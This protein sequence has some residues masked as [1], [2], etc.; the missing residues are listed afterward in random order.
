[1]NNSVFRI[2]LD[3]HRQTTQAHL[4]IKKGDTARKIVAALSD[5]GRPYRI[6]EGCCAVFKG[7]KSDG[8]VLYN[9][10]TVENNCIVYEFTE[11][12]AA[13]AGYMP[14]EFQIYGADG[15]I[16]TSP[17]FAII[18]SGLVYDDSEVESSSEFTALAQ[19]MTDLADLKANGL[20]GDEGDS[21]YEV[22][23]EDGF[24]GTPG[25]WLES[26]RGPEGPEGPMGKPMKPNIDREDDGSWST[27]KDYDTILQEHRAGREIGCNLEMSD[28]TRLYVPFARW[29]GETFAFSTVYD[30]KEWRVEIS[31]GENGDTS[32]Q[33]VSD[34]YDL[35]PLCVTI[36]GN[37]V[38]GYTA[39]VSFKDILAAHEQGRDVR[40]FVESATLYSHMINNG[41]AVFQTVSGAAHRR[42]TILPDG[43]VSNELFAYALKEDLEPATA[44]EKYFDIDYDGIVSLKAAYRGHPAKTTYPYAI[45]D[46]GVGVDGSLIHELPEKIVIPDVINGTAVSGFQSGMFYRN[47]RV[48]EITI[49]D[50]VEKLP[51][52]FCREA[53]NLK[54]IHNTE[55]ITKLG[56]MF[57]AYTRVK[58]AMF[59]N[60]KEVAN[61]AFGAASF[62]CSVDIGNNITEI[63][64]QMFQQCPKLSLVN[65]GGKVTTI[66]DKAFHTTENLK[67]LPFLSQVTSIG[68]S[69]FFQSRIQFDWSSI[70]GKCTFGK[71]ATPVI[72]NTT[73][74]WS[75][76][77]YEPCTN[78]LVTIMSQSNALWKAET[79]GDSGITY[80]EGCAVFCCLHIHSALS[81]KAY[82]HPDE[83]AEELR[84]IDPDLVTEAKHPSVFTNV[85]PLFNAL[86]Y[87]TTVYQDAITQETYQAICNALARG[88]YVYTQVSTANN[89]NSGHTA[90]LYGINGIGEVLILNSS[91]TFEKFRATGITDEVHLSRMPYQN[92]SGPSSNIVI[93]EK[94]T[95]E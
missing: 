20:K 56:T 29:D 16:I 4:E 54:A 15:Q 60:L 67:N 23:V 30:G 32:V 94:A 22:A 86:G 55:H 5:G 61:T 68:A 78:R 2:N 93:V 52:Y 14:C 79:F 73:D 85:A 88:A 50:A 90:V 53:V 12:T 84:A 26:L 71:Y 46:N 31:K 27:D 59:P 18:V 82:N 70:E 57:M 80:N 81:G 34:A 7:E 28:E 3:I 33:V 40:C 41:K 37:R 58:K 75:G 47:E 42:V 21:A 1:M 36:T 76:V 51:E 19:A 9:S 87:K 44:E 8:N 6:D 74:Y 64:T 25:E 63:P 48:K 38:D 10:C 89:E 35:Q 45:S 65:G 43:A 92:L 66:G 24:E 17:K 83:F 95:D 91:V 77:E 39:D 11:Q 49:P 62:L 69:A 13:S 72:D